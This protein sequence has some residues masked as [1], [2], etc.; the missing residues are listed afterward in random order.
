MKDTGRG[1]K[2]IGQLPDPIPGH[3]IPLAATLERAPPKVG[4]EVSERVHRAAICRHRVIC[5]EAAY[6]LPQPF[7]WF[8]D[9]LMHP[10]SHLLFDVLELRSHSVTPGFSLQRETPAS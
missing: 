4:D 1:K 10:P 8:R 9:G 7:P 6:D 2:V 3:S 5:K